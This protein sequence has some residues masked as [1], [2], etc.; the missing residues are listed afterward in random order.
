MD[1]T[2]IKLIKEMEI[3]ITN[4]E[5][6]DEEESFTTQLVLECMHCHWRFV[7]EV[8]RYGYGYTSEAQDTPNYCPMCGRKINDML[9]DNDEKYYEAINNIYSR[10]T[11]EIDSMIETLKNNKNNEELKE[12]YDKILSK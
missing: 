11:K 9:E 3:Q 12:K 8:I 5:F 6:D 1:K 10:E 2:N 7:G 4:E